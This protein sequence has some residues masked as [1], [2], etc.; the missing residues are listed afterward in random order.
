MPLTP[1][2]ARTLISA[3]TNTPSTTLTTRTGSTLTGTVTALDDDQCHVIPDDS[4][5]ATLDVAYADVISV[6]SPYLHQADGAATITY[7]TYPDQEDHN[8]LA[9]HLARL[10]SDHPGLDGAVVLHGDEQVHLAL[11]QIDARASWQAAADDGVRDAVV[12]TLARLA[13]LQDALA[14]YPAVTISTL[15]CE[16]ETPSPAWPVLHVTDK[17]LR[18]HNDRWTTSHPDKHTRLVSRLA[19]QATTSME[20]P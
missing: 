12:D 18:R 1:D 19:D 2:T 10:A 4:P 16:V 9:A 13:A 15:S 7:A 11:G 17:T 3:T 20:Q 5:T 6:S 8:R 14:D